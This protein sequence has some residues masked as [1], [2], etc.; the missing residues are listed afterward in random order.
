MAVVSISG[1]VFLWRRRLPC[2]TAKWFLVSGGK[3][4]VTDSI[5]YMY[6]QKVSAGPVSVNSKDVTYTTFFYIGYWA[7]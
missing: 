2:S 7:S 6:T 5:L 1:V 4:E 3:L